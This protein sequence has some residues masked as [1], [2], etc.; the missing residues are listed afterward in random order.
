MLPAFSPK[1]SQYATGALSGS[2]SRFGCGVPVT[3][4][5]DS[6]VRIGE[7]F[8]AARTV[9]WAAGVQA[10]MAARWLDAPADRVGRV[11]VEP[12]LTVPGKPEIFVIGDTAHVLV[13]GKPVPGVAPAAKQQ[14]AYVASVIRARIRGRPLPGPFVYRHLGD[15][16][17]IGHSAAVIDFGRIQLTGWIGWWIWGIAHIYFLIGTRSRLSVAISW[18]WS[19]LRGQ[20]SARLITQK[21]TLRAEASDGRDTTARPKTAILD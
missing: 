2:V 4:G 13:D 21:E 3:T 6:G 15:L 14:G 18:L 5:D 9:I 11:L 7:E 8:L 16:A 10:S 17:T 20:N 12:D 19:F 1:L